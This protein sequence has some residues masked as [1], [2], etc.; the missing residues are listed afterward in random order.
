MCDAGLLI[1]YGYHN[2]KVVTCKH[3]ID[4]ILMT[5]AWREVTDSYYKLVSCDVRTMKV[6]T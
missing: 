1:Y 3:L 6:D 5:E 4:E 2:Y